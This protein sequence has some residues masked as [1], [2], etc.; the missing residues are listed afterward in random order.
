MGQT[1]LGAI[2]KVRFRHEITG[3]RPSTD[4]PGF[5]RDEEVD[6]LGSALK[7]PPWLEAERSRIAAALPPIDTSA[8]AVR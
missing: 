7:L 6:S 2:Q 4:G 8:A 3:T 5:D 1:D